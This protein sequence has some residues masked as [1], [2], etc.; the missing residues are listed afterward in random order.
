MTAQ[1]PKTRGTRYVTRPT[2]ASLEGQVSPHCLRHSHG[3]PA[4]H[5]GTDLA[6][7]RETLGHAS[8]ATTGRY[9]HGRPD[10]SSRDYLA[11]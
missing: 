9:L 11:V 7:A 6:T 10:K 4:L 3:T 5:R 1:K 2:K 8:L